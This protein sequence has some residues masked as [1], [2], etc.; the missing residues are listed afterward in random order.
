VP[1]TVST[2]VLVP[3]AG[4]DPWLWSRLVPEIETRGHDAVAVRLPAGD[5][6]AGWA[7]YADAIEHAIGR[8]REL[9]L[10]AQSLGGFSAPLV[11][12]RRPVAMI[13]LLNAMIPRPG[14]NGWDWWTNT[15]QRDAQL[16]HLAR[17]GM[18]PEDAD[19]DLALYF[20]DMPPEVVAEADVQGPPS[21]AGTPMEQPWPLERWPDVPTR[22]LAGRDDRLFPVGFQRR[23]A[24]ERL[25]LDADEIPGGHLLA[26]SHPV[27]LAERLDRYRAEVARPEA[28]V[29]SG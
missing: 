17:I 12:E 24:R 4:G 22:V 5:E 25:G 14:E 23:I 27:E 10:V 11:A 8:R 7:E 26:L 18:R 3:G 28:G 21:Q 19:D 6:T 29:R 9:I 13:V 2:F 1:A 16:E 15:G 20:H